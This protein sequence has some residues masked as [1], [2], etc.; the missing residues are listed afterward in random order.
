MYQKKG[1]IWIMKDEVALQSVSTTIPALN[2]V[3]LH[4]V[5]HTYKF[6]LE[7]P[8]MIQETTN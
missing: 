8:T 4:L 3:L 7:I 5:N 6:V 1:D 2:W